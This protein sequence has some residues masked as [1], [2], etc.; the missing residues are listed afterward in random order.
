M[1]N[2][3]SY[4]RFSTGKQQKGSSLE[5]QQAM[6]DRWA[7]ANPT[8]TLNRELSF[9]DLGISGRSGRHLKSGFG[10]LLEAIE[11]GAIGAGDVV[12]VEAIDRA[13]RMEPGIMSGILIDILNAGVSLVTLDD[14]Q[15]YTQESL[16]GGSFYILVGKVQAAFNYSE[17]LS[18]RMKASYKSRNALAVAGVTP[19]RHTPVWLESDG[20]LREGIAPFIKQAFED[21]AAGLGERRVYE[22]IMEKVNTLPNDEKS[23]KVRACFVR[24]APSTVKRWMTNRT[25]LGEW[26]GVPN[27]YPKVVE[28][29]LFYRVQKRKEE[30]FSPRGVPT[31]HKYTGLVV[32][33]ECGKN[34]NTKSYSKRIKGA[35][36]PPVMECSSR[37]R[38]GS[39]ACSNSKGIPESVI[40]YVFNLS[41]WK[42]IKDA[43]EGQ[44]LTESQKREVVIDGELRDLSVRITKVARAVAEVEDVEELIVS[45]NELKAQRRAL[46]SEKQSLQ[47]GNVTVRDQIT[48]MTGIME[49]PLKVNALLQSVGYK[50]VCNVNRMIDTPVGIFVYQGWGR[51]E[52]VHKVVN[53]QGQMMKLPVVRQQ[54]RKAAAK[55][56][57]TIDIMSGLSGKLERVKLVNVNIR[58]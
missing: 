53:P 14:N 15:V 1:N 41:C 19:K 29:E 47:H 6:L 13:G 39:T 55:E 27:V 22:R 32:C 26:Q 24:M 3:Y 42:H 35:I 49:D 28:P 43:L 8:F 2:A 21:Y 36:P 44:I 57:K 48:N 37:A 56:G 5:R 23:D 45:L 50:I 7:D 20:T 11:K 12:L 31:K 30:K 51:A 54:P 16:R 9:K 18:V 34:F 38:R 17:S 10:K 33:G 52:D 40:A 58:L 25:V 4:I 46:E